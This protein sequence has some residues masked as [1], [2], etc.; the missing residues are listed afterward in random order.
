MDYQI[1]TANE[2]I[3]QI[4]VLYKDGDKPVGIYAIDVPVVEGT[5]LTGD[6]LHAEIMHRAPTWVSQREQEV[7]SASGFDQIAALVQPLAV[8]QP[9]SEAQANAEMWA[10]IEFEK[11][12]AKALVKFGLLATD[13]TSVETTQL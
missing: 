4:E 7:Q 3:G 10:Q 11:K 6:A 12:V 8:D 2:A 5:F 9:S 13:P 1:I